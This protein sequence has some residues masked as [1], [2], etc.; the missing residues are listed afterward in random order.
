MAKR[1]VATSATPGTDVDALSSAGPVID[2][3]TGADWTITPSGAGVSGAWSSSPARLTLTVTTGTGGQLVLAEHLTLVPGAEEYDYICRVD[4]VTGDAASGTSKQFVMRCGQDDANY[5]SI[6]LRSDGAMEVAW[7][8]DGSGGTLLSMTAVSGITSGV[9]TG[10]NLHIRVARRLGR[11]IVLYGIGT[12]V[13][14]I[15][16]H[17]VYI[18]PDTVNENALL[19]SQGMWAGIILYAPSLMVGDY[20]VDVTA[21][22]AAAQ[23]VSAL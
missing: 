10:G 16:W 20:V 5:L 13:A 14:T 6:H 22:R 3:L 18:S 17:S 9:R 7:S 12:D 21:I 8:Y 2:P 11:I 23:R 15:I 4:V 19:A 1:Y